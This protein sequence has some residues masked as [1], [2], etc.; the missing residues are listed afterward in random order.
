MT[1]LFGIIGLIIGLLVFA[2]SYCILEEKGYTSTKKTNDET[3]DALTGLI[4]LIGIPSIIVVFIISI[5]NKK[6]IPILFFVGIIIGVVLSIVYIC[7][8]L[9]SS[10]GKFVRL[11]HKVEKIKNNIEFLRRC[12]MTDKQKQAVK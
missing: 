11:S 3:M 1:I 2:F 5:V 6:I 7:C 4:F 12:N 10:N 8:V 9:F